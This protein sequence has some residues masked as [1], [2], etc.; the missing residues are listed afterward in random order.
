MAKV[1][2]FQSF[3]D[4]DNSQNLLFLRLRDQ[5]RYI[6]FL[7]RFPGD[8]MAILRPTLYFCIY[9]HHPMFHFSFRQSS[10]PYTH[11]H[12]SK[13]KS[14]LFNTIVAPFFGGSVDQSVYFRSIEEE[15]RT[16][17]S[18]S[19]VVREVIFIPPA[20]SS[21]ERPKRKVRSL[22]GNFLRELKHK[23]TRTHTIHR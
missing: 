15:K 2:I 6:I 21:A 3:V 5:P 1:A 10:L 23:E 12:S 19:F 20:T 14:I 8:W 22:I 7:Y 9:Y 11:F 16:N 4:Q 17:T 18:T 13:L